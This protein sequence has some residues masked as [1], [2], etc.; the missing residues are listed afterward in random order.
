MAMSCESY[1]RDTSSWSS[2]VSS[3]QDMLKIKVKAR[4]IF[5][6]FARLEFLFSYLIIS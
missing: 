5:L 1:M 6:K 4:F 3:G 2:E